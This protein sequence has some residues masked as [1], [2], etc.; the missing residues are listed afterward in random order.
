S[1]TAP[2]WSSKERV[3]IL[4]LGLDH[5]PD[6]GSAPSRTDTILIATMDPYSNT[7]GMLSIPRD[8][9]VDIPV[10][11]TRPVADRIN[12]T[13]VYAHVLKYVEGGPALAKKTIEYNFG[14]PIHYYV[15]LDFMG[16]E[17]IVDTL[18]G[19][20]VFL[21]KPLIDNEYPTPDYGIKR[22]YIPE[23]QQH[24]NGEKALWYVR[25]RHTDSDFGR[26][27]RQQQV[28]MALRAKA[29]QLNVI[30]KLPELYKQFKDT[31]KT[32]IGVS[33]AMLLTKLAQEISSGDI[34][35]RVLD[36]KQAVPTTHGGAD[37]LWPNRQEIGKL[38][39][40]VFF[41]ARSEKESA[42]I[43]VLNGTDTPGL[44]AKVASYLENQGYKKVSYGSTTDYQNYQDCVV[45][46][47]TG[48][49][50]T[51]SLVADLLSIP[52][53]RIQSKTDPASPV[54]IRLILG[55]NLKLPDAR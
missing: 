4:V 20:D 49:Q 19:I 28:I 34:T 17:K 24:L 1:N 44:A 11:K 29:L 53:D 9:W 32:D 54:D 25:S 33:D 35:A 47:Y 45:V 6:E 39:Q 14:I 46:D 23:G 5:R 8:L 27:K 37:I 43:E 40:E 22:I 48:K 42:R 50:Y 7:A 3:N 18:G 10:D 41:D 55:K 36:E 31:V 52:R 21:E 30:P 2:D 13:L 38:V 26:L 51:A 15:I 16:F 12:T